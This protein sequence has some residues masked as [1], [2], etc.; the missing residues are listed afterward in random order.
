MKSTQIP[1]HRLHNPLLSLLFLAAEEAAQITMAAQLE[2]AAATQEAA[3]HI[4]YVDRP[5]DVD[6]EEFHICT[7]SPVLGRYSAEKVRDSMLYHY[8]HDASGFSVKLTA[9]QVENLKSECPLPSSSWSSIC[10]CLL[11]S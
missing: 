6:P 9:E 5:E 1:H 4:I 2:H 3:V 8:K 10:T 11:N 7:L